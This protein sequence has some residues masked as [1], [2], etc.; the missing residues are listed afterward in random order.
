MS[1]FKKNYYKI[2]LTFYSGSDENI[3]TNNAP[4]YK[5]TRPIY[6]LRQVDVISVNIPFS[7]Y[8]VNSSNYTIDFEDSVPNSYQVTLTPGNYS[9]SELAT[10]IQSKMNAAL[11]GFTV[12]YDTKYNTFTW[13]NGTN[14]FKILSSSTATKLIGITSDTTLGASATSDNSIDIGGTTDILIKS[15]ILSKNKMLSLYNGKLTSYFFTVPV[16]SSRNNSIV[17]KPKSD[18]ELIYNENNS[19]IDQIDFKLY[20]VNENVLDLNGPNWSIKLMFYV[21][22]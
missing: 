14:N 8:A 10:E 7:Y 5:L 1:L 4:I 17:Y 3:G 9:A 12:T 15:N 21:D 13:S 19:V 22:F 11:A 18:G 20:D 2:P 6:K 16:D